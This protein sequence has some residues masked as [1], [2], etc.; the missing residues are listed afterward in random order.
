[1]D[2]R[3]RAGHDEEKIALRKILTS[4]HAETIFLSPFPSEGVLEAQTERGMAGA[5]V[6]CSQQQAGEASGNRPRALRRAAAPRNGPQAPLARLEWKREA[7]KK[8]LRGMFQKHG[9]EALK[10]P[11]A[12]R[13]EA[14]RVP[15][16]REWG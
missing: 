13:C 2:A 10:S 16:V 12:E 4:P 1:M 6:C 7:E 15:L 11:S 8:S 3:H 14:M 9:P 5:S